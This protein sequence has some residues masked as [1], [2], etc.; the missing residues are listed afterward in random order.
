[1]SDKTLEVKL[2]ELLDE[3][4]SWSHKRPNTDYLENKGYEEGLEDGYTRGV[5]DSWQ[6]LQGV[7][8]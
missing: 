2:K 7:L 6:K 3:M 4:S 1:M 5:R 8:K